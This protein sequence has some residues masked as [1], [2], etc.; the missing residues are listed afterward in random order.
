[1]YM[2][3]DDFNKAIAAGILTTIDTCIDIIRSIEYN[4]PSSGRDGF[5]TARYN[6]VIA[7]TAHFAPITPLMQGDRVTIKMPYSE[8]KAGVIKYIEPLGSYWVLVDGSSV[9]TCFTPDE[10]EHE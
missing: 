8:N 3:T 6:A 2:N 10:V 1:M 5:N 9:D 4:G 7:I